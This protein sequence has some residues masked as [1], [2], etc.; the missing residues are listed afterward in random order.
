[1]TLAERAAGYTRAFPTFPPLRTDSRWLDGV[2][3]L[4]NNYKGSGFYGSYPPGYLRRVQ[5]LF[6]DVPARD[7]LHL[8]S[9]SLREGLRVDLNHANV[10]SVAADATA[11]P[12]RDGAFRLV[13]ADPPYSTADAVRY[14]TPMV[15]RRKVLREAA[16]VTA[17]SG[18]LVWL[19]TVLPM[20]R[21]DL[22]H[23]WGVIGIVRS[24]NHRVRAVFFFE[25]AKGADAVLRDLT[26]LPVGVSQSADRRQPHERLCAEVPDDHA[27]GGVGAADSAP[28]GS[29]GERVLP[30][31]D[32]P[33]RG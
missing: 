23:W 18:Y 29:G 20:F 3:V 32:G 10:P 15:D 1:M 14:G 6:P 13:Y 28:G 27:A 33:T 30:L 21:K 24:T 25:R 22:W 8:F 16:R 5:S 4:G 19:D 12:F 2:W 17:P 7:T 9:G 26:R 11:L 31:G